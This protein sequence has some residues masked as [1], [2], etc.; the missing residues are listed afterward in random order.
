MTVPWRYFLFQILLFLCKV[1]NKVCKAVFGYSFYSGKVGHEQRSEDDF[2]HS[3]HRMKVA[4]RVYPVSIM[5]P[6]IN[7][8]FILTHLSYEDPIKA[9]LL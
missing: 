3:A 4:Y 9:I 6:S 7:N 1:F 8:H 5:S 2:H